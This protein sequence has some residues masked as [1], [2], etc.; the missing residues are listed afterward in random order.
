MRLWALNSPG[1]LNII[2]LQILIPFGAGGLRC[3]K[4]SCLFVAGASSGHPASPGVGEAW[5]DPLS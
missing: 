3:E 2:L 4:D 1:F 5:A